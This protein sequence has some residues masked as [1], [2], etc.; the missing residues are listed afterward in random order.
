M[1]IANGL[2]RV[3]GTFKFGALR[4]LSSDHRFQGIPGHSTSSPGIG[5]TTACAMGQELV[6]PRIVSVS[7]GDIGKLEGQSWAFEEA[8]E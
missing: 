7:S 8:M 4:Q 5:W 3:R 2:V 6:R 1:A